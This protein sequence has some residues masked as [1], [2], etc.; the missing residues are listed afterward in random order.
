MGRKIRS[1]TIVDYKNLK[2]TPPLLFGGRIE[3]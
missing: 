2:E 1:S 3:K